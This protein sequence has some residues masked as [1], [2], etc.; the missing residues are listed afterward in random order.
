MR[1]DGQ[2]FRRFVQADGLP[3]GNIGG[4][5]GDRSDRLWCWTARGVYRID[6]PNATRLEPVFVATPSQLNGGTFGPVVVDRAGSLYA[7]TSQGS[8]G[9]TTQ[10]MLRPRRRRIASL[11]T[12][13]DGLAGNEVIG[14]YRGSGGRLCSA[15]RRACPT[16][17]PKRPSASL[18]SDSHRRGAARRCR[19]DGFAC[20]RVVSPVSSS[21]RDRRSSR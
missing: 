3:A 11:Y 1:Y 20:G 14:A 17:S 15:R 10:R 16:T 5:I 6:D 18:A 9:S 21:C 12:I 13:S 7:G 2:R 19:S 8:Y 4:A